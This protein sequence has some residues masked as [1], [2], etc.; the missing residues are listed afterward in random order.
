MYKNKTMRRVKEAG[1]TNVSL[2][3][4]LWD[5]ARY[6][7]LKKE[8]LFFYIFRFSKVFSPV[9]L[10]SLFFHFIHKIC[11]PLLLHI[12]LPF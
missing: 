7:I 8:T 11:Q 6:H 10:T 5:T 2:P 12:T 4:L 3:R 9:E 1:K